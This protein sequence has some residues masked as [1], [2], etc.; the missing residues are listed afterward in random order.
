MPNAQFPEPHLSKE[1]YRSSQ[2]DVKALEDH[3]KYD[4]I[5]INLALHEIGISDYPNVF[6][7]LYKALKPG[8]VVVISE[9]HFPDLAISP[10][11]ATRDTNYC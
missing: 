7:R 8:G 1:P 10:L 5:I 3:E 9:Y 6:E 2:L 11:I 4:L